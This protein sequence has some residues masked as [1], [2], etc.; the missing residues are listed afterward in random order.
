M[1]HFASEKR[2]EPQSFTYIPRHAA[3]STDGGR[4]R[5]RLRSSGDLHAALSIY[6]TR[7]STDHRRFIIRN[8][9]R[10]CVVVAR[11][12]VHHVSGN[13][14]VNISR[15]GSMEGSA[16]G[17]GCLGPWSVLVRRIQWWSQNRRNLVL[18]QSLRTLGRG[19]HLQRR[20]RQLDSRTATRATGEAEGVVASLRHRCSDATGLDVQR[21]HDAWG[22]AAGRGSCGLLAAGTGVHTTQHV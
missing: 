8:L 3:A 5:S 14:L 13:R 12:R 9:R 7:V 15:D 11:K 17:F 19:I 22:A 21:G 2:L 18:R 10:E 4:T 6:A 16:V 1:V 20:R